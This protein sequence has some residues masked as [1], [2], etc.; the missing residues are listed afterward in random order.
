[1][2]KNLIFEKVEQNGLVII[3]AWVAF[4]YWHFDA[5]NLGTVLTR[6]FTTS[7]FVVYGVFTQ[8]LIN[9]QKKMAVALQKAHQEL[10]ERIM[11]Q[12][13]G[14]MNTNNEVYHS[15]GEVHDLID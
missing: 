4:V 8:Y 9:T 6:F 10:L 2:K 15:C 7:L 14:S 13:G 11:E 3:S 5:L 1:M 12:Q